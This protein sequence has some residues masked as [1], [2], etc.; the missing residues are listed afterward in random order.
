MRLSES[1]LTR[2]EI[3]SINEEFAGLTGTWKGTNNLYLSWLPDPL[4]RSESEMTV[5]LKANGQFVQFDYNWAY[6]G[7]QQEGLLVLGCDTKSDDVQIIWTDSWHSRHVFMVSDG[8]VLDD[9]TV[10]AK[11]YYK[12]PDHPDWGWRTDIQRGDD[13]IKIVM[14]NVSPEGAEDLAVETEYSRAH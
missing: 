3:M 9:G 6:E 11:G 8:Q 5:S 12:V 13:T 2:G 4:R 7:E 1:V 10:T 14:Y